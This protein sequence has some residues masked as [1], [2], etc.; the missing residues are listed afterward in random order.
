MKTSE[1]FVYI[2]NKEIVN[3]AMIVIKFTLIQNHNNHNKNENHAY[4]S[5]LTKLPRQNPKRYR[6]KLYQRLTCTFQFQPFMQDINWDTKPDTL[7]ST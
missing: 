5:K 4:F 1:K 7:P 6:M 3:M 2:I